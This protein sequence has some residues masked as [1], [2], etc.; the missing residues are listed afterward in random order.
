MLTITPCLDKQAIAAYC[1]KCKKPYS[2][3]FYLYRAE[4]RGQVLAAGLFEVGGEEVC[5][6]L[7]EAE[8]PSDHFLFDGILRAGLNYASEQGIP[9]GHI[10]E[11]FRYLHRELFAKLN[12]PI[13]PVFD[14]TNFFQKYKNCAQ[15]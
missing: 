12:Y 10:P 6:V 3:A 9:N 13:Q 15:P 7:Y 14:I 8:D 4:N 1:K 5:A 2:A 11:D